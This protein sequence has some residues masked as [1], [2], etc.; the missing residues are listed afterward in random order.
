MLET[1]KQEA[2]QLEPVLES[3]GACKLSHTF[4]DLYKRLRAHNVYNPHCSVST[5]VVSQDVTK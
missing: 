1:I 4:C 3:Y 2:L 5:D